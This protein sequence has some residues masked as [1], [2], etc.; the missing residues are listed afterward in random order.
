VATATRKRRRTRSPG[1]GSS[2]PGLRP[3]SAVNH[4]PMGRRF[5][6]T[7]L[8]FFLIAGFLALLIR[9]QLAVP[10]NNL[11][12]PEADN[13]VFTTHGTMMLFLFAVPVLQGA[14]TFL[15][16]LMFGARDLPFP[17]SAPSGA[18]SSAG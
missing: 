3:L 15:L 10:G 8:F 2:P 6:G 16:P 11:L 1:L 14:A 5:V 12:G 13:Q 7:A 18:S 17:P 9:T 4:G